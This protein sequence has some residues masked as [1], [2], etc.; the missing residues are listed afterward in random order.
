MSKGFKV[1]RCQ[2]WRSQEKV[3]HPAPAPLEPVGPHSRKPGVEPF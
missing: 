2:S 3:C 1:T